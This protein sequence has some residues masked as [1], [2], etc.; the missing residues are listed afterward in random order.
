MLTQAHIA[1]QK[2]VLI[3]LTKSLGKELAEKNIAVNA[4]TP[5]G[6]KTRISRPNV[7]R[8]CG[9]NAVKSA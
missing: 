5:A 9:K 8:T 2:Q 7:K 4:V 6:A 1:Q 3:G